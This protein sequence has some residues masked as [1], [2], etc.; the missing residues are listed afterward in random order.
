VAQRQRFLSNIRTEVGR[1]Q[2]I[3]ERLLHLSE[4]ETRRGLDTLIPVSLKEVTAQVHAGLAPLFARKNIACSQDVDPAHQIWGDPF[5]IRQALANLVQ[6]ALDFSLDGG[7][8]RIFS[9]MA[10]DSR[11]RL[12]VED[13]GSGIPD[14]AFPRLFNKFFSLQRP[15]TQ[16]KGTGLG[17]NF[18]RE[19]ADLHQ[20]DI[21]IE[22][23]ETRGVRAALTLPV[24]PGSAV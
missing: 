3:V 8:I 19:V 5:L 17:L 14:Y 15:D 20:G 12:V 6:N 7:M 10:D 16:K 22:N 2:A 13:E 23:R 11:I 4:L 9:E 1:I 18:V 24:N 21:R